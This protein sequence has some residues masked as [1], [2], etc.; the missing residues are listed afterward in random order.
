M[1]SVKIKSY[2]KVNLTLEI[3]G[4]ENGFHMLDSLVASIDLFDL[5]VL[6]KRKDKLSSITM[7]G[8]GS[9]GIPPEKNNALK[10]AEAFSAEFGTCGA[11]ITVYK[12]IPMGAGLG[13]SSAD[14]A[15]VLNGMARLYGVTDRA[16]LKEVAD[17]LGSDTGY[18]LTGG[19]ARMQG[20]G[21]QVTP[22]ALKNKL[23]LLLICP[24]SEVSSGACYKKYDELPQTLEWKESATKLC[25]DALGREN[26][27]EGGRYLMNDLYI[28]A[29]Y[30]NPDV[31][32][33]YNEAM[34]FS[35]FGAVMTGSGS[36]VLAMFETKELCQWAQSRYK[37]KFRTYVV[38]TLVPDYTKT[39]KT[40]GLK[41]PF[42]LSEAEISE[43]N[44][45]NEN[46]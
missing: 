42:V 2:A 32:K 17:R 6:K 29:L 37:G 41:N 40:F 18:M 22:L 5:I 33:A 30:L 8:M 43:A 46:I 13:G 24:S 26:A 15:G 21:E 34:S 16:A 38:E 19:F 28:P 9:E 31:E 14:V 11:D 23:H 36:C 12:N 25:I 10:A 35:P 45:D 44:G 27:N 20:R 1:H 3:T 39:K 7:H 4:V